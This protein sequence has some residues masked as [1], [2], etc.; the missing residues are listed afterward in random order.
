MI[1]Y[2]QFLYNNEFLKRISSKCITFNT[3]IFN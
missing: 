3:W 1:N 2:Y